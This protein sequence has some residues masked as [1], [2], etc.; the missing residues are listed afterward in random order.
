MAEPSAE[1]IKRLKDQHADRQLHLVEIKDPN[2]E[3]GHHFVMT[4]ANSDEYKKF[5][6]DVFEARE[7]AKNDQ[8]RSEK[9]T[10]AAKNAVFRQTVWP[11]RDEVKEL[12]HQHPG[13]VMSLAE[14][15][16]EHAGSSAEVRS[17]KL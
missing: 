17:K 13:F 12:L 8:E 4:G 9:L 3:E 11:P 1:V 5:T 10:F 14:K 2:D 7:K 16:H 6:D 15:I